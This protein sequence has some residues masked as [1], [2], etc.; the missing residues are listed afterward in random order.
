MIYIYRVQGF[1]ECFS[2]VTDAMA[3]A[4]NMGLTGR[5]TCRAYRVHGVT[6]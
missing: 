1:S 2:T 3:F 4:R 6:A 5:I